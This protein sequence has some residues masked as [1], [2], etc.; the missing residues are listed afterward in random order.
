MSIELLN[1]AET[2]HSYLT[3]CLSY[4]DMMAAQCVAQCVAQ[5]SSGFCVDS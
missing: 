2:A 4:L 3:I 5:G 1:P